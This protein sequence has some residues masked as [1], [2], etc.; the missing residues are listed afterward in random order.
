MCLLNNCRLS[1]TSCT[2][3]D[4]RSTKLLDKH[5]QFLSDKRN[6]CLVTCKCSCY[7]QERSWG[8]V[9]FSQGSMILS[10]GQGSSTCSQEGVVCSGRGLLLEGWGLV[11]GVCLQ[12]GGGA[13]SQGGAVWRPPRTAAAAGGTHSTGM[14][15]WLK[16]KC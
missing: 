3:L 5:Q 10:R 8:K 12:A 11:S 15:S 9:I 13:C 1:N 2:R 4:I 14:H 7:H 16:V 6:I